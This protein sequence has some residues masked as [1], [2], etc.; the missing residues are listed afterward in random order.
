MA[1]LAQADCS[2]MVTLY[3]SVG[4]NIDPETHLRRGVQ[5]LRQVFGEVQCSPVYRSAAIG[6]TGDDFLNLVVRAQTSQSIAEVHDCLHGIEN[7]NGRQRDSE[8]FDSRT[9]DLDLL[10]F[11]DVVS[12]AEGI[13]L[14]R[15][16]ITE[17]ACVLKPLVDLAPAL[18]HPVQQ[19]SM[20]QLWQGFPQASQPLQKMDLIV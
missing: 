19:K 17:H 10:L 6:F 16:E 9:L 2:A 15:D 4:S 1:H 11:D 7:A 5:Q 3:I 12:D 20:L 14:P 8:K 13:Q 18:L